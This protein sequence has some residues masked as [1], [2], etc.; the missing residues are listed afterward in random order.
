MNGAGSLRLRLLVTTTLGVLLALLAA[1]LG[2][3]RL[4]QDHAERQF[5]AEIEH[6]LDH[7]SALLERGPNGLPR[8][9]RDSP[10]PQWQRP[11]SGW[12]AQLDAPG[13]PALWRTRSLWDAALPPQDGA[14]GIGTRFGRATGPAGEALR[15]GARRL[16]LP[17]ADAPD[18]GVNDTDT[19][20]LRVAVDARDL[21]TAQTRFDRLLALSLGVLALA[22][23]LGAAAQMAFALTPVTRLQAALE[24]VQ[25]GQ[26]DRLEGS[27]PT[28]LRPLVDSFNTVLAQNLE[29]TRRAREQAGNLAHALKTPLAVLTNAADRAQDEG[30]EQPDGLAALVREQ[31]EAA[32][33]HV[34]WHLARARAAAA[35][36]PGRAPPRARLADAVAPLVRVMQRLNA[37]RSIH[38][39]DATRDSAA[40][41]AAEAQD[42]NEMLGN[43]LDNACRAARA[44]VSVAVR[45][46][47]REDG[48]RD[49][50]IDIDDDGPGLP[51]H[52]REYALQRGAR[53]DERQ[54]GNGL[55]LAIVRE[56]A[57][58]YGGDL[59]LADSPAGGLRAS[60][61]LPC[62]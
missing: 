48:V 37:E 32:H 36:G 22:L 33:R 25:A 62:A 43:L 52:A 23:L 21:E 39:E 61:R 41:V 3:S 59:A 11:L 2:L 16:R 17:G 54:P 40:A 1:Y 8:L 49:L 51:P 30:S 50:C 20:T 10:E 56:L 5:Q 19:W 47:L 12:Y 27:Y 60:L 42:L 34:Q 35:H 46:Q 53:L 28:E 7:F 24:R 6:Q 18:P 26:A 9:T 44:R 29:A 38:I 45:E 57:R 58:L 55:G 31:V 4:F 14:P 15:T 13:R